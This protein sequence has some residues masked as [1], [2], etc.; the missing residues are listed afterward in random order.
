MPYTRC[1]A[2]NCVNHYKQ[3]LSGADGLGGM[4]VVIASLVFNSWFRSAATHQS[5][6]IT[7]PLPGEQPLSGGHA[8]LIVGY[9]DDSSVPGGGYFIVR[10]SW[11]EEWASVSPE[12]QGHALMPYA[13]VERY[14]VEAFSGQS[15]RGEKANISE[16]SD[17]TPNAKKSA[18]S[19]VEQ[20]TGA[21]PKSRK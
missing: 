7:M 6:K 19:F 13:Y 2:P 15:I 1:I 5:G 4:P 11:G 17:I 3:V 14:I 20:Y 12:A 8:M 10:N 18:N 21:F 9:Q 16:S